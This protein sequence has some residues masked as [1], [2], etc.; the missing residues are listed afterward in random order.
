MKIQIIDTLRAGLNKIVEF[1][2]KIW[3]IIKE[4][5]N[6]CCIYKSVDDRSLF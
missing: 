4:H 2:K 1:A 3:G 5:S 6:E